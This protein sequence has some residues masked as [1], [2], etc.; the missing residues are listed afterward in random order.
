MITIVVDAYVIDAA[1]NENKR[2]EV[3][4]RL[5]RTTITAMDMDQ[6]ASATNVLADDS[7]VTMILKI[8]MGIVAGEWSR[9]R[10]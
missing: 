9:S 3:N 10:F 8:A 7:D 5:F 6:A 4:T 2:D 1:Q